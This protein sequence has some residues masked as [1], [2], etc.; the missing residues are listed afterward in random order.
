[1]IASPT[2]ARFHS[3]Q[4]VRPWYDHEKNNNER[5]LLGLQVVQWLSQQRRRNK[6]V[7]THCRRL[8]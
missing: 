8:D 1:M 4:P 2:A 7:C 6:L 5:G 3:H